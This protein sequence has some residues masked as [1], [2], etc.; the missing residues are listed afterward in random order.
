[1]ATGS[2][3]LSACSDFHSLKN[4]SICLIISG[5]SRKISTILFKDKTG[6][7]SQETQHT[8]RIKARRVH[9]THYTTK[10]LQNAYELLHPNT[11]HTVIVRVS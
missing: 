9:N 11:A 10:H 5:T 3:S 4:D 7:H 8:Q 1:M 6:K 2:R